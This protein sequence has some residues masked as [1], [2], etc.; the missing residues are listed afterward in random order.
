MMAANTRQLIRQL[1][2]ERSQSSPNIYEQ[3]DMRSALEKNMS[4]TKAI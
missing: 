3:S 2:E 4:Q 1:I